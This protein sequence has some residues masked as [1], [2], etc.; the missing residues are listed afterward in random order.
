MSGRKI[1]IIFNERL[2]D[3]LVARNPNWNGQIFAEETGIFEQSAGARPDLVVNT[4]SGIPVV[5]ETEFDPARTV[6][7]DAF[8]RIGNTLEQDGRAIEQSVALCVPGDIRKATDIRQAIE[9]ASFR[10]CV[11]SANA[12]RWPDEGWFSVDIDDLTST[13]E[14]V[15]LS[16]NQLRE[17]ER[18]LN[19]GI[20]QAAQILEDKGQ[21]APEILF[22]ISGELH[23]KD[24]RQTRGMAMSIIANALFFH[25]KIAG[26]HEVKTLDE[27]RNENHKLSKSEILKTWHH[28]YRNIN[29]IP[30]FKTA[31]SLLKPIPNGTAQRILDRLAR[32]AGELDDLGATTQHDLH[33][34][35]FQ[36]LITDRKFLASFYTLPE[37]ARLLAEI[38][39]GRL[40]VNWSDAD[41][42]G[43]LRIGDFACGTGALLNAA[44]ASIASRHR[45]RGGDGKAL[46]IKMME[47]VLV[48]G[49]IL[50]A[51]THLTASVLSS[52]QPEVP[53]D[54][55]SIVTFEYGEAPDGSGRDV[56]I[57]ALDLIE[58]Q[59]ARDLFGTG[60]DRVRGSEKGAGAETLN[61]PHGSFDI[62]IMNPP[63]T[64][65][66]NHEGGHHNIPI[67][68]F[69]GLGTA[70]EEQRKMSE[71]LRKF[72]GKGMVGDGRAGLA[73][74]FIDIAH[75]KI[76]PGGTIAFVLSATFVSGAGWKKVRDFLSKHYRDIIVVSIASHG[77]TSRAF[78]FDT[79][80]AEVLII[81]TRKKEKIPTTDT[82][83]VNLKTRPQSVLEAVVM[84]RSIGKISSDRSDGAVMNG[85]YIKGD[86]EQG[87]LSGIAD[88]GVAKTAGGI[89]RGLL[90]LPRL[91]EEIEIPIVDLGSL[92][93]RGPVDREISGKNKYTEKVLGPF[94]IVPIDKG[95]TPT[96]PTLW[97]HDATRERQFVVL[98]DSQGRIRP[99]YQEKA[100]NIWATASCL[101]LNRDFRLNS[102]SLASCLTPVKTIGG[103]A[104]PSFICKDT[105]WEIPLVLWMNTILGLISFWWKGSR[106]QQG[107]ACITVSRLPSLAVLDV[108]K[109]SETGG[110]GEKKRSEFSM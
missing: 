2:K 5:V 48:G 14:L 81:A 20:E 58:D 12:E 40:D 91:L 96:Y 57:G 71:K 70:E 18:I 63:F 13:I 84:A 22:A 109:L 51:A 83:F 17:G 64:R 3:A 37:S 110:G 74:N 92:G 108:R 26:T 95:R 47:D 90:S 76:K 85:S 99:G 105:R 107:R 1:E 66:T 41:A 101:H 100:A 56:A 65:P 19:L 69:A 97:S 106:Q 78:S 7:D 36:R 55:T 46:H 87:G 79:G 102:Q 49:D 10:L 45:H 52:V 23:Q 98:P 21:T 68:S 73:S 15:S 89:Y 6:E 67:P 80:M 9:N 93:E 104:W 11:W 30:I 27:H 72:K 60:Q 31:A 32:V 4:P 50:P 25:T 42:I 43:R 53:F 35:L 39:I 34:R 29:Y 24:S 86:I 61:I 59:S 38:A 8:N 33:G 44:Y 103:R 16:E 62:V 28:I 82:T 75:A 54:N 88:D 77:S 94:D